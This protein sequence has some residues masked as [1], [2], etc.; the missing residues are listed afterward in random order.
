MSTFEKLLKSAKEVLN[1]MGKQKINPIQYEEARTFVANDDTH[2]SVNDRL[3]RELES[4]RWRKQ[5]EE[6]RPLDE[7]KYVLAR[8]AGATSYSATAV[9]PVSLLDNSLEYRY[10]VSADME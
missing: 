9:V 2:I 7:T 3:Q 4:Q 1:H 10:I 6:P 8:P 5:K